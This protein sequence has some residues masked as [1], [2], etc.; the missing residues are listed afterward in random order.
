MAS[1]IAERAK[2]IAVIPADTGLRGEKM[3]EVLF[4]ID[5]EPDDWMSG[6]SN[7]SRKLGSGSPRLTN[8]LS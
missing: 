7:I 8:L 2:M 1:H 5:S 6:V 4:K 3:G